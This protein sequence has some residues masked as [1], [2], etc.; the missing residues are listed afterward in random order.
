MSE[1]HVDALRAFWEMWNT[2]DPQEA[3]DAAGLPE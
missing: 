3:L 1:E 2:N